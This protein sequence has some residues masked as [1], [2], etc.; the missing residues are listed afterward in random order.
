V[1]SG[2]KDVE[3]FVT[4][5][6]NELASV[7]RITSIYYAR[8]VRAVQVWSQEYLMRIATNEDDNIEG[9]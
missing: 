9:V 8:I 4:D 2:L 3:P 7:H 5:K 6:Y 1:A